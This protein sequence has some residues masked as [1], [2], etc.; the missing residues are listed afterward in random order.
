MR[1]L[2]CRGRRKREKDRK[3]NWLFRRVNKGVDMVGKF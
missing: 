2:R 1:R 3:E